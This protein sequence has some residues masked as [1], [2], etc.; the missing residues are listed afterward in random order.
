MLASDSTGIAWIEAKFRWQPGGLLEVK[1]PRCLLVLTGD[2]YM[3][4]VKRGK[5]VLRARNHERRANVQPAV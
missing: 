2:D 5:S 3:R 1:L 4:G